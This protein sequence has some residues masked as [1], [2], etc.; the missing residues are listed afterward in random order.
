MKKI[1]GFLVIAT[2]VLGA[3][4]K[5]SGGGFTQP[6]STVLPTVEPSTSPEAAGYAITEGTWFVGSEVIPGTYIAFPES[7]CY[8]ER[9]SGSGG[10]LEEI[11]ANDNIALQGLVTIKK[12]DYAF[13][14]T[15]EGWYAVEDYIAL[16]DQ[17]IGKTMEELNGFIPGDGQYIV[18]YDILPGT[19]R[20]KGNDGCYIARLGGFSGELDEIISNDFGNGNMLVTIKSGDEGFETSGCYEWNR[21]DGGSN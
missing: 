1:V 3:C 11:E 21:V 10:T 16:F 2:L 14:T 19:Y 18:G 7:S 15:C 12:S 8:W 4:G 17:G 9:L 13:S 5:Q 20:S 6:E